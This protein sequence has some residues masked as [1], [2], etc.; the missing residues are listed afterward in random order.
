MGFMQKL[1]QN[2]PAVIIFLIV[3]FVLLIIFEWGAQRAGGGGGPQRPGAA[4]IGS[5][6]GEDISRAEFESRV[7]DAV[8]SQRQQNP[9]TDV[10]EQQIRDAVWNQ[11]VEE[12]LVKQAADRLGLHVSDE[13]LREVLLYDP[14]SFL[15]TQF[16]DSTGTFREADYLRFM[17]DPRGMLTELGQPEEVIG[18]TEQQLL[19]IQEAIRRERL[20]EAVQSVVNASA[21]PSPAQA[22]SA[23]IEQK[24]LASGSLAV[25]D[26]ASISDNDV[27][28]S[29]AE[30]KKF[31]DDH[32]AD[33]QQ[34]ASR[35]IHYAYFVLNPSKEDSSAAQ[36]KL[37]KISESLTTATTPA[38]KDSL[39]G[40]W[41]DQWGNGTFKGADFTPMQEIVPE[42]QSQLQ[43]A[44]PGTIIGPI[45]L[46]DGAHVVQVVET[47]DSGEAFVKAQH[48][49]LKTGEGIKEDS[50]KAQIEQLLKRAKSGENFD[51]LAQQYSG[52]GGSAQ[53]GG[54]LGYFKKEAMVKPFSDAAFAAA[55]G[56]IVGPVKT[57]YG[58][59]II[60]VNDRAS[61]S[62]KLRDVVVK[63]S[64][65]NPTR[66]LLRRR[67]QEFQGKLTEGVSIDSLGAREKVQVIPSGPVSRTQPVVG[68]M[69]L[70][71]FAY[72]GEEGDVSEVIEL[73][74]GSL[75][76][77]Q[78]T[79][80]RAAGV[81]DFA[82]AK[83]GIMTRIRNK[84]KLE[85]LK[86][87]AE[88]LRASLQPNDSL[89]KLTS[90]DQAVQVHN[91]SG[92]SQ[93]APFPSVGTDYPLTAAVFNSMKPGQLS[94]LIR[95]ERGY[96]IVRLDSLTVP[97]KEEFQAQR[98]QF[99][100]Q[101]MQQRRAQVFQDWIQKERE[102]AEIVD[103]RSGAF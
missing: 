2:M 30:A 94:P 13:E 80:V 50:V 26:A 46:A 24:S 23:F 27:T 44:Q 34:K 93:V 77:A 100:D 39:M 61:K 60:K 55:P 29:D 6:N 78:I 38:A 12:L 103:L 79:K 90:V 25:L 96:Y 16:T 45:T 91:F 81:Q 9:E 102:H 21:I 49:L 28:I 66:N 5:V 64:V 20:R 97:T 76:V 10:D 52:D 71:N 51:M 92:L 48:I 3:M 70:T 17:T 58:Y 1:R 15:K 11:M 84:K 75:A 31:Y 42:L 56:S 101:L 19:Q 4:A 65:S 37:S 14:P 98:K 85:I 22:F 18:R 89:S 33:F 82:D 62:Y 54:D 63:A 69:S 72:Q 43:G 8:E 83:E 67:A 99:V 88:K 35:E 74:D 32:K 73:P 53:R 68:S 59:H 87:R 47:K 7:K 57:D 36:R 40:F 86:P 41:I 95:G